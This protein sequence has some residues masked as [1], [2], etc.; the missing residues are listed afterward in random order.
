MTNDQKISTSQHSVQ[1][2]LDAKRQEFLRQ[3]SES[4]SVSNKG[5]KKDWQRQKEEKAR[6]ERQQAI[7]VCFIFTYLWH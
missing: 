5:N 2:L 3:W 1:Q 6:L 7:Q 4:S